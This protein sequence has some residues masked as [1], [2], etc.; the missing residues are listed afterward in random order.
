[1]AARSCV[2]D[3]S[4]RHR[5]RRPAGEA[6]ALRHAGHQRRRQPHPVPDLAPRRTGRPGDGHR[7]AYLPRPHPL[8]L[9]RLGPKLHR[10]L[11]G[12]RRPD[13]AGTHTD[14]QPR[15]TRA[16][17]RPRCPGHPPAR[18]LQ[19]PLGA[20][21]QTYRPPARPSSLR[22]RQ[23]LLR[24]HARPD[25]DVLL[26]HLRTPRRHPRAGLNRQTRS[27]LSTAGPRPRRSRPRDRHRLGRL[28]RPRRGPLRLPGHHHH[29]LRRP[30]PTTPPSASPRPASA[31]SSPSST[32]T[33][34][35]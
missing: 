10:G 8:G 23:R 14:P 35:I 21:K 27:H 34:A 17:R 2:A 24:A 3:P 29:H 13:C 6:P 7:S 20:P 33:T 9:S 5:P 15:R 31:L 4:S 22:P 19:A 30:V 18:R 11:V 28:R 32:T 12:L 26:R 16:D 25:D 1:M